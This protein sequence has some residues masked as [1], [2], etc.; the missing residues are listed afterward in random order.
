MSGLFEDGPQLGVELLERAGDAVGDCTGLASHTATGDVGRHIKLV[1]Q[2]GGR[3]RRTGGLGK[4]LRREI[5]IEAAP[6]GDQLEESSMLILV[7]AR[8]T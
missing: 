2:L 4:A 5:G 1:A 8:W 3:E 6:I 7:W